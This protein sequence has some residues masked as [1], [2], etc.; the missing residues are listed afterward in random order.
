MG[1]ALSVARADGCPVDHENMSKDQIAAFMSSRNP[2]QQTE[3]PPPPSAP[4]SSSSCPVDHENMSKEQIAAFMSRP[5]N[6]HRKQTET[7]SGQSKQQS[8]TARPTEASAQKH[9]GESSGSPAHGTVYDVYGQQ[10]DASNMMPATPNQLPSPGQKQPLSTDR[11]ESTIPKSDDGP[12]W[13]YP[14][15]QMF[16]NALKRKGKADG[17]QESDMATVVAVHNRMNERTWEDLLEWESRFHCTECA[18]PTLKRFLGRP[19]D[20]SP[21]ARFRMWF[22]GY[23]RPFDRHD[24][25]VDRCGLTEVRYII[26]Y[27]FHEG[28]VDPIE[29]HVRPAVESISTAY[30]RFRHGL[31][32]VRS[33]LGLSV[34]DMPDLRDLQVAS[35]S[36]GIQNIGIGSNETQTFA[37][38]IHSSDQK[39]LPTVKKGDQI[40]SEE[41]TFLSGLTTETVSEISNDVQERCQ[42]AHAALAAA[43]T[44]PA[45]AEQANISLNYCMAQRICKKQANSFM[46]ALESGADPSYPYTEMTDCL[47]RFQI[48]ARRAILEAAGIAQS[49]PEFPAGVIPSVSK[50]N[51]EGKTNTNPTTNNA[52]A[53]AAA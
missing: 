49:G 53:S 32:F 10:L 39:A 6:P 41:F 27:Y 52:D 3:T 45:K 38:K 23:P 9:P 24:W 22:R 4:T 46:K 28:A 43:A 11:V 17:V 20:L 50:S 47:D 35:Q 8:Q 21:A 19:H 36:K 2:Q 33:A 7:P 34:P 48:M 25:V 15:P 14:S 13:V 16:F 31:L 1:A 40:D 30:D 12:N 18:N 42:N 26:D 29:I 5:D 44:D 37:D 51:M